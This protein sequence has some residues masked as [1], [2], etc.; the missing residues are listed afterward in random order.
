MG[1]TS[2]RP[3]CETCRYLSGCAQRE[4]RCPI[5]CRHSTRRYTPQRERRIEAWGCWPTPD[6]LTIYFYSTSG[7]LYRAT[8]SSLDSSFSSPEFITLSGK[9]SGSMYRP[10][11][12]PDESE[13]LI[14]HTT[15]DS[16]SIV[17]FVRSSNTSYTYAGRVSAFSRNGTLG[18]GQHSKDG[19][20]YY[21]TVE[22][23]VKE[24]RVHTRSSLTAE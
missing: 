14:Y 21:L 6:E 1:S 16:T 8:R 10:S 9:P 24:L 22:R 2:R 7:Y 12:T 17:R 20:H 11:L 5:S 13:L 18:P 19:L 23:S 3:V 4:C 15:F